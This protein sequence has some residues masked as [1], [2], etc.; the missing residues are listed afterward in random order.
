VVVCFRKSALH[1]VGYW[2]PDILT[3]DIDISWKLQLRHWDVR[4]EPH[5]LCW[6]LTPETIKGLWRQRVR[7]AMGGI[8]VLTKHLR[9]QQIFEWKSR[10]M[11]MVLVEYAMSVFWAY[12]ML[13]V[14]ILWFLGLFFEL[15]PEIRIPTLF[16]GWAGVILG[17]TCLLQIAVSLGLDSRYD[18]GGFQHFFWMIWY[19][20]AYWTLSMMA[21][22][23][24][25]PKAIFRKPKQRAVWVSPDRGVGS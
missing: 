9:G 5:A 20:L 16:S 25:L 18:R 23:V 7:W 14:A 21:T 17:T 19:P 8:Q 10:R 1:D 2:S 6:I 3:E 22:V 11:W 12:S 15:P 4:F 24:A 13:I